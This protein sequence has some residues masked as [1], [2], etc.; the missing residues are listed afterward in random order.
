MHRRTALITGGSAGIGK[1]ITTMLITEGWAVTICGR[2]QAKLDAT[3]KELGDNVTGVAANLADPTA[4]DLLLTRHLEHHGTLDLLVNN[5]G[6]GKLSPIES[7]SDKDL[8]LEIALNFR[9]A[10]RLLRSCIPSLRASAA[11]HGKST[12]I[13]VSSLVARQSPPNVSVYAATKAALVALSHSAHAE[14][15][16]DGIQVTALLPGFVETPGTTWAQ[17]SATEPMMTA[18]DVAE[19]V[20]FLLR[21]SARCF[22]PELML[23]TA[24]PGI[25]HSP[26]DW[27]ADD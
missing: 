19:A 24:G 21:T 11:T 13:N 1:A 16:R 26:V 22:V 23:T 6:I 20:R 25:L 7:K 14:L 5:V 3:A 17:P 27:E 18:D 12:V 9:S 2:D 8:D 15:S 10:F 4:P